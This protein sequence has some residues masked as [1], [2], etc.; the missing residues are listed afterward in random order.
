[1]KKSIK[2]TAK[3]FKEL[4]ESLEQKIQSGKTPTARELQSFRRLESELSR[5]VE[6][7]IRIYL[8]SFPTAERYS[9]INRGTLHRY[10]KQGHLQRYENGFLKEDLDK[11]VE[12][13]QQRDSMVNNSSRLYDQIQQATLRYR[14]MKTR[15]EEIFVKQLQG[16]FL[17]V[18]DVEAVFVSRAY[19]LSRSLLILSRRVS[20]KLA[21]VTTRD[22]K[23]VINVVNAEVRRVM[24][25]YSRP[26]DIGMQ[27]RRLHRRH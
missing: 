27:E 12:D 9:G 16:E 13:R 19:E 15:R 1:M 3:Q 24:D 6:G 21:T 11:L 2:A 23:E 18:K 8:P 22:Y 25:A 10:T 14:K 17:P 7:Q 26:L 20:H 5:H 4:C